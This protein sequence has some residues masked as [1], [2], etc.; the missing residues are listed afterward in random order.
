MVRCDRV[1]LS[2]MFFAGFRTGRRGGGVQR[3]QAYEP[4]ARRFK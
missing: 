2:N 3:R 1:M 4:Y